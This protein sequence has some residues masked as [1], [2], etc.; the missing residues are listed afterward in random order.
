[1]NLVHEFTYTAMLKEP[2][3][4]GAGPIG[5]RAYFELKSDIAGAC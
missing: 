1:M 4:I 2:L 3:Q 5:T